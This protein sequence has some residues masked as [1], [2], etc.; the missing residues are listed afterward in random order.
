MDSWSEVL[1]TRDDLPRSKSCRSWNRCVGWKFPKRLQ[2]NYWVCMCL[3][4]GPVIT[5]LLIGRQ[6]K[7]SSRWCRVAWHTSKAQKPGDRTRWTKVGWN[8]QDN[9]SSS[10]CQGEKRVRSW[11]R[12]GQGE[13]S[14]RSRPYRHGMPV[15]QR[16]LVNSVWKDSWIFLFADFC[17]AYWVIV[18]Q[19]H[20]LCTGAQELLGKWSPGPAGSA[21]YPG[22][23]QGI[24]D[25]EE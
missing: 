9:R 24:C 21:W 1:I 20:F 3:K 10:V 8:Q 5:S 14:T 2:T 16:T 22:G 13:G 23:I 6:K 19:S 18:M 4:R 15:K 12:R 17:G 25:W 11:T 7:W